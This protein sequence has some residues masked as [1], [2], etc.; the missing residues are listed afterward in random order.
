[1]AGDA[2]DAGDI[3]AIKG[4]PP[5]A[6]LLHRHPGPILL[7]DRDKNVVAANVGGR[8]ITH[9][10]ITATAPPVAGLAWKVDFDMAFTLQLQ[11]RLRNL[12]PAG[13]IRPDAEGVFPMTEYD[14]IWRI[15]LVE[16]VD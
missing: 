12:P 3:E 13:P 7:I 6:M 4:T 5:S 15:D 9:G 14:V 1:M 2:A 8:D 10:L 11:V 16:D